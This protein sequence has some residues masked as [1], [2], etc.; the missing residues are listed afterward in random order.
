[1]SLLNT[2]VK[3]ELDHMAAFLQ[4]AV[5]YK[6]KIGHGVFAVC[7]WVRQ[8]KGGGGT[9]LFVVVSLFS[10]LFLRL[11]LSYSFPSLLRHAALD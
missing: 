11:V 2:D 1:M 9:Y 10:L 3:R 5:D 4:M 7:G 6:A 8:G